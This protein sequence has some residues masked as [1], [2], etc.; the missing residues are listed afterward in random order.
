MLTFGGTLWIPPVPAPPDVGTLSKPGKPG[1]L[2]SAAV[3]LAKKKGPAVPRLPAP[4]TPAMRMAGPCSNSG[5][6][7]LSACH[8]GCRR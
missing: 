5:L 1:F 7:L 3:F 4:G 2:M 6:R 8:D